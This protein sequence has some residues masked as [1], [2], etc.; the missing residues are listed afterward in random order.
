MDSNYSESDMKT[1]F[2]NRSIQNGS[3]LASRT[4]NRSRD[5]NSV[6]D[7]TRNLH[8]S[9]VASMSRLADLSSIEEHSKVRRGRS[10]LMTTLPTQQSNSKVGSSSIESHRGLKLPK[11]SQID[12]STQ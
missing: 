9:R 6:K 7:G 5:L 12:Q 1:L 2:T 8:D 4:N 3:A 10:K 11:L